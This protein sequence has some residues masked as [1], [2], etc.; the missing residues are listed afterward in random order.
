MTHDRPAGFAIALDILLPRLRHYAITL[1]GP[2]ER[3]DAL[4]QS[5][6]AVAAARHL[7]DAAAPDGAASVMP[8]A[9][10][11]VLA[12]W[13]D[14]AD[15]EAPQ[16]GQALGELFEEMTAAAARAQAEGRDAA[17]IALSVVAVEL[18]IAH[19]WLWLCPALPPVVPRMAHPDAEPVNG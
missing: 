15:G 4:L 16:R 3:S 2:G 17:A 11:G 5:A 19:G 12:A 13:L 7:R 9:L 10:E 18:E 1:L 6:I 14:Q 8:A